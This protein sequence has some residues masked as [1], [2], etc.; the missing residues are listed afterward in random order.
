LRSPGR[1]CAAQL[2]ARRHPGLASSPLPTGPWQWRRAF[3]RKACA[4]GSERKIAGRARYRCARLAPFE[5]REE[6]EGKKGRGR[7][8]REERKGKKGRGRKEGEEGKGKKGRGR[9]EGEGGPR[10][11]PHTPSGA[12]PRPMR[13]RRSRV[14]QG[15]SWTRLYP[16]LASPRHDRAIQ[17]SGCEWLLSTL[18]DAS[19][20]TPE[21]P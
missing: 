19:L 12:L 15:R 16:S 2:G 14:G 6:G 7:K 8:E 9:K 11:R 1:G 10:R 5:G 4:A 17:S 13:W 18:F 3:A 20:L 21:P